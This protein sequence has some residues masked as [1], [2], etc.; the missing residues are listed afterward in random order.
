MHRAHCRRP[1]RG[2]DD[3]DTCHTD[4]PQNFWIV[5]ACVGRMGGALPADG[6]APTHLEATPALNDGVPCDHAPGKFGQAGVYAS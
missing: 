6:A 2:C 4:L 1:K 3:A 5:G